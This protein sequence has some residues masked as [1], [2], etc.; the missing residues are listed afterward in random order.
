[1]LLIVDFQAS[2]AFGSYMLHRDLTNELLKANTIRDPQE[3]DEEFL[4]HLDIHAVVH[5][6]GSPSLDA[7]VPDLHYRFGIGLHLR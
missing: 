2:L 6:L 7:W 1:L 5:V 4:P 3:A